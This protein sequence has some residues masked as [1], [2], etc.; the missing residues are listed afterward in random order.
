MLFPSCCILLTL[1]AIHESTKTTTHTYYVFGDPRVSV[2][3]RR[4]RPPLGVQH[5]KFKQACGC[6]SQNCSLTEC[7]SLK[8]PFC[9]LCSQGSS[10]GSPYGGNP[11]GSPY[12]GSPYGTPP[13]G[14][15]PYGGNPYGGSYGYHG[16]ALRQLQFSMCCARKQ[17][18]A[19]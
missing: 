19:L 15:N 8:C 17:C 4:S 1:R 7:N 6:A 10:Y 9:V 12:G 2:S 16:T 11:Y 3:L 18:N 5:V 14:G 13:Y